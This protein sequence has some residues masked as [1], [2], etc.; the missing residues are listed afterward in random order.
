MEIEAI[1]IGRVHTGFDEWIDVND[2]KDG[3]NCSKFD[4][5]DLVY[6]LREKSPI[7]ARILFLTVQKVTV[8]LI[9]KNN[10]IL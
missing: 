5:N 1:Y 3:R 2:Y 10:Y 4:I 6:I 8:K 9:E 7:I